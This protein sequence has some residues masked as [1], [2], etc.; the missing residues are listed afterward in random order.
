MSKRIRKAILCLICG[1][2]FFLSGCLDSRIKK[3]IALEENTLQYQDE[4]Q[5]W[6]DGYL[7]A[8]LPEGYVLP[9]QTEQKE[10][11]H[12]AVKE[13]E[14]T[15]AKNR[16]Q[17]KESAQ[18]Y[19]PIILEATVNGTT[20]TFDHL[21]ALDEYVG[22]IISYF[23]KKDEEK[24]TLKLAYT[25]NGYYW[26]NLND[27][28]TIL[29]PSFG[30]K[31]MRDP[32]I[33]R[34]KDGSFTLIATQGFDT[35]SIYAYDTKDFITFEGERLIQVNASSKELKMSETQAWAPE[36][37]YDRRLDQY[38]VYWSSVND[39]AMF[40]NISNDMVH[41]SYPKV[42]LDRGYPVIDGTIIKEHNDYY[43]VIKDERKPL[44]SYSQLSLSDKSEDWHSFS[45]FKE[46]FTEHENEGP[47]VFK[48]L[49][50][51]GYY[52]FYDNYTKVWF[53]GMY[54]KQLET[55]KFEE[56]K[57]EVMI[58]LTEPGHSSCIPV[59]WKELERLFATYSY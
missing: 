21:L 39:G 37:F 6:L 23:T 17:K 22:Y 12:W 5:A 35:D 44:E 38:V 55:G 52:V 2:F 20:Y 57:E 10:E 56:I 16:I 4:T 8:F 53:K 28:K 1:S 19:E 26:F 13:G 34:K 47:M 59:T 33:V 50:N 51:D 40:Y 9:S 41:F 30:T 27:A 36:G 15:L 48:D 54:I 3:P 32:S 46:P 11:I 14:I 7:D 25:Y 58:P 29:A 24:E 18:E 45:S 31:S 42:L 49:E 43:I